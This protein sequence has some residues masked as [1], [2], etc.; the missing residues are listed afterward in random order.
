PWLV[1]GIQ[2][3]LSLMSMSPAQPELPPSG[4]SPR[5]NLGAPV[6][7]EPLLVVGTPLSVLPSE[8]LSTPAVALALPSLVPWVSVSGI[9]S[10]RPPEID[11]VAFVAEE[12]LSARPLSPHAT[13]RHEATQTRDRRAGST[14]TR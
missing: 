8:P 12:P 3:K 5:S 10:V 11:A 2:M 4:T 6:T 13:S 14:M 1:D 9:G 7:P